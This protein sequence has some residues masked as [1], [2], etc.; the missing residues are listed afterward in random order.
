ML[1]LESRRLG[2]KTI[3]IWFSWRP[4]ELTGY[5]YVRFQDAKS[6]QN[7]NGFQMDSSFTSVIDLTQ[8][9]DTMWKNMGKE[10]AR[11]GIKRAQRDGVKVKLNDNYNEFQDINKAFRKDKG[12]GPSFI[13]TNVLKRAGTLVVAEYDG[14]IISGQA[15]FA[16]DTTIR[17]V[18][19]GSKRL[20][21]DKERATLIGNANRLLIWEAIKYA[22]R[23]GIREFDLGGCYVGDSDLERVR[24]NTWKKSFGGALVKRYHYTK[25]YSKTYRFASKLATLY[26]SKL[27]SMSY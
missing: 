9:L 20:E 18:Y 1:E 15:Y 16:D 17:V 25:Y 5:H 26:R 24:V 12:L 11:R 7:L 6:K 8:G 4:F 3:A 10:S 21:V 13:P 14:E 19:G 22:K 27:R 2:F 23:K